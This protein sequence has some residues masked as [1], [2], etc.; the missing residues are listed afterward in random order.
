MSQTYV[1]FV[2]WAPGTPTAEQIER[3]RKQDWGT[4][5]EMQAKIRQLASTVPPTC[6]LIGRWQLVSRAPGEPIGVQVVEVESVADLQFINT[7]YAGWFLVDWRPA[8]SPL[9]D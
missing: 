5:Q 7:Y 8:A 1:G 9:Q 2:H 6:K 4:V 3:A